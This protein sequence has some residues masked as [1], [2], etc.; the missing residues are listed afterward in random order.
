MVDMVFLVFMGFFVSTTGLES[1]SF[2]PEKFPKRFSFGSGRVRFL[3]LC[4]ECTKTV[5]TSAAA[6]AVVT[7]PRQFSRLS[8]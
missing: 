5:R 7:A 3:L 8:A 2:R 1:F 4:S 6:A